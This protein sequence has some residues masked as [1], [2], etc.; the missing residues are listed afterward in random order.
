MPNVNVFIQTA[1]QQAPATFTEKATGLA[2]LA[3]PDHNDAK[4][5]AAHALL[6]VVASSS[7]CNLAWDALV[8]ERLTIIEK[9]FRPLLATHR[10]HVIHSANLYLLGIAIYLEMIRRTPALCAVLAENYF[11]DIQALYSNVDSSYYCHGRLTLPN[12]T[13]AETRARFPIVF[14]LARPEYANVRAEAEFADIRIQEHLPANLT[15]ID[16]VFRRCWGQAAILHDSAYPMELA[17]TLLQE[18]LTA[19][20]AKKGCTVCC[21]DHL[22]ALDLTRFCDVV[23]VPIVQTVC[24]NVINSDMYTDNSMAMIAANIRH[25][26][27]LEYSSETLRRIIRETFES[28]I[29]KGKCDHGVFSAFLMLKWINWTLGE[30]LRGMQGIEAQLATGQP[31][32]DRLDRR[33]TATHSASAVEFF[34]V[35][36]MDAAAAVYLHN[37]KTYA[38]LLRDRELD[39]RDH[40]IAWMLFLCDQLQEW[41]RPSNSPQAQEFN[42]DQFHINIV[43]AADDGPKL[44]FEYPVK[45]EEIRAALKKHLRL[46]KTDFV[47]AAI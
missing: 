10:D 39:F 13:L 34:Y 23:T 8:K 43:G 31:V 4:M 37:T 38:P 7:D 16:A 15:D 9:A 17:I 36:C 11:R 30:R 35:E 19:T 45:T 2:F 27:H 3:I 12:A 22:F 6:T 18:Y 20:V 26:L 24:R 21:Y 33:V 14:D 44:Y 46:F 40:P 1:L 47:R 25:K 29:S 32:Q 5:E 28:G 41:S 42:S